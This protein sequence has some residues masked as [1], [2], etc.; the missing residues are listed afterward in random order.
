MCYANDTW[1]TAIG[2]AIQATFMSLTVD[3][4]YLRTMA[5]CCVAIFTAD[6]IKGKEGERN[7]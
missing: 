2:R 5:H 3:R 1:D 6:E 7:D 4:R